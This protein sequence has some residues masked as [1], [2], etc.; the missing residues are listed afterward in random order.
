MD[1]PGF[2]SLGSNGAVVRSQLRF[3]CSAALAAVDLHLRPNE[4]VDA[5]LLSDHCF[6]CLLIR[7]VIVHLPP[8]LS[9]LNTVQL[10]DF[11]LTDSS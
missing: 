10:G 8:V 7:L 4:V 11:E 5:L 6:I 2:S 9:A 1:Q 3:Y